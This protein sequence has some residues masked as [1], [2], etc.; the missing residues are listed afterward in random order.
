MS[1]KYTVER[2]TIYMGGNIAYAYAEKDTEGP[3]IA[4]ALNSYTPNLKLSALDQLAV[5]FYSSGRRLTIQYRPNSLCEWGDFPHDN[6][7]FDTHTCWR[8]KPTTETQT[9]DVFRHVS[10]VRAPIILPRDTED[11][12]AYARDQHWRVVGTLTGEVEV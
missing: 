6:P 2:G 5:E 4:A 11:H 10:N 8:R 9:W 7:C 3:H 1:T 12:E